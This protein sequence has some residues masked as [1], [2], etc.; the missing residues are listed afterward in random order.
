MLVIRP[1][2]S[3]AKRAGIKLERDAE[4]SATVL[5]DWYANGIVLSRRQYILCMSEKARLPLLIE[6][7]PYSNFAERLPPAVM[8]LLLAIGVPKGKVDR[9][10]REMEPRHFAKTESRSVL[11]SMN[12]IAYHCDAHDQGGH[13]DHGDLLAM[14]VWASEII[15]LILEAYTPKEA[16]LNLFGVP[17]PLKR[18]FATAPKAP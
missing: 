5:G 4:T 15:S 3:L 10:V 16:A 14:S 1:T 12:E 2:A 7:A 18:K 17:V 11:G 13:F 8:A 9:E 6:A